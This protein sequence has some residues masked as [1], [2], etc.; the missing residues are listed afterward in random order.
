MSIKSREEIEVQE[1]YL[2]HSN[3]TGVEYTRSDLEDTSDIY[4]KFRLTGS[5][6]RMG[7]FLHFCKTNYLKLLK[8]VK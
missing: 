1:D 5:Q 4:F 8:E 7:Y 3:E 2:H 6:A